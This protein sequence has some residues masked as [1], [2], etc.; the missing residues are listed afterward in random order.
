[1][2]GLM[3]TLIFLVLAALVV[4]I[5]LFNAYHQKAGQGFALIR[6]GVGK[7]KVILDGGC[8]VLPFLH[9]VERVSTNVLTLTIA[10]ENE[11]MLIAKDHI[12]VNLTMQFMLRVEPD[13]DGIRRVARAVGTM[14]LNADDLGVLFQG[15]F[16]DA[17]QAEVSA[18]TLGDLHG[19]RA[20]LAAAVQQ[21][22][23]K[24]FEFAGL[25]LESASLV[26]FDQAAP[27][28]LN[29]NNALHV[30]GM[31]H[32]A[33]I[34]SQSRRERA[35]IEAEAA[36]AIRA[37]NLAETRDRVEFERNQR[38]AEIN[39]E[40]TVGTMKAESESRIAVVAESEA[41]LRDEARLQRERHVREAEIDRDLALRQREVDSLKEA[42]TAQ[43]AGRI[44]LAKKRMEEYAADA[45]LEIN[46]GAVIRAQEEIQ[47]EKE[48][49][50]AQRK[51]EQAVLRA[52]EKGEVDAIAAQNEAA[53]LLTKA[54]AEAQTVELQSQAAANEAQAQAS[55]RA[56]IIAAENMMDEKVIQ[57]KLEEQK[58]AALPEVAEKIS[59]PLEKIDSIRINHI[60]GSS[61]P[62]SG[63]G[64]APSPF[65]EALQSIL[66]M[67]VQ[68]P[69]LKKLGE[70]IGLDMDANL[71]TRTSDAV[72]RTRTE[73]I[74]AKT[75]K[76]AKNADDGG[77]KDAE[78][79]DPQS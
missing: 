15:R 79:I 53:N 2:Y 11:R 24:C 34:V 28:M 22:L 57:M 52:Q 9:T 37:T 72:N 39:L 62:Q 23:G 78:S 71:A 66:A 12:P 64:H 46:R 47:A 74:A 70:E 4:F 32:V 45:E 56:A 63:Q 65:T 1:M 8:L 77:G 43:I 60:G 44:A 7:R 38:E 51:R 75:D 49:L 13:E 67:S 29:D 16:I 76:K 61:F 30:Q 17:M 35:Q 26:R 58:I 33:A 25:L 59:K 27:S 19:N 10:C 31:R 42:E 14:N 18:Q 68:L 73:R 20:N 50:M 69:A 55:G 36:I 6:T 5:I 3:V 21:R 41:R 48:R 40:E 54:Q